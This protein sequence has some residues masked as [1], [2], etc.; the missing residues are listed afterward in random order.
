MLVTLHRP[1]NVDEPETLREILLALSDI[2]Q[3]VPV[4]F[5]VHPRTR[6]RMEDGGEMVERGR[7]RMERGCRGG[8]QEETTYLGVPCLTARANTERPI[9]VT[10]GTNRLVE[11]N[12][13]ALVAAARVALNGKW[14]NGAV[15][16]L[17]DG[18]AARRIVKV[19]ELWVGQE[20]EIQ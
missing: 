16:E 12:R 20:E 6:R 17:W 2:A 9:T 5:P 11:S 7:G 3:E 14:K 1:S 8:I 10:T 15:P 19:L 18:Q 13:E 4:I